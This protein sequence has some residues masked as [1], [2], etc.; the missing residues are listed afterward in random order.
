M[1]VDTQLFREMLE[2]QQRVAEEAERALAS[3]RDAMKRMAEQLP[4]L[5]AKAME[6]WQ[7]QMEPVVAAFRQME[8]TVGPQL[9]AL[10][11]SLR[12]QLEAMTKAAAAWAPMFEAANKAAL[13]WAAQF[14]G[15]GKIAAQF[16]SM[17]KSTKD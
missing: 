2:Q 8:S 10:Q 9:R 11:K 3:W 13:A 5:D 1:L 17:P 14:E 6:E 7:H 4:T 15:L 12:P 16:H